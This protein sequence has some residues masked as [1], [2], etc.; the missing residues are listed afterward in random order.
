MTPVSLAPSAA[1]ASSI[2]LARSNLRTPFAQGPEHLAST[3]PN[4]IKEEQLRKWIH[5]A[6]TA[7]GCPHP[8]PP[9]R[10]PPGHRVA[11]AVWGGPHPEP[12]AGCASTSSGAQPR[13]IRLDPLRRHLK[14][15]G[16]RGE[17]LS[18]RRP[19]SS[20]VHSRPPPE[21]RWGVHVLSPKVGIACAPF[22]AQGRS[23]PRSRAPGKSSQSNL[24][25]RDPS[26]ALGGP[27]QPPAP[28]G[29][30]SGA[31]AHE[32]P[33]AAFGAASRAPAGHPFAA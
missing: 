11:E 13:R 12:P 20:S 27:Q 33:P 19:G 1:G 7:S 30:A 9:A 18:A 22:L 24:R 16:S 29:A 6:A 10:R 25:P 3:K 28:F 32:T 14:A 17:P 23:H 5:S 8:P 31:S 4:R 26:P 2:T 15:R 21:V